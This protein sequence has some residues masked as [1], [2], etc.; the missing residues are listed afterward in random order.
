MISKFLS[1]IV[2]L[3]LLIGAILSIPITV[4][5]Q[6]I[7]FAELKG[8]LNNNTWQLIFTAPG[9]WNYQASLDSK[10][11]NL[12]I[13]FQPG[14]Q[15]SSLVNGFLFATSPIN[16][17]YPQQISPDELRVVFR[18]R[19]SVNMSTQAI[20]GNPNELIITLSP[21]HAG[22]TTATQPMVPQITANVLTAHELET[23]MVE[24]NEKGKQQISKPITTY[25]TLTSIT[26]TSP[27][28]SSITPPH[29]NINVNASKETASHD[30]RL[31]HK[32]NASATM[33]NNDPI[34]TSERVAPKSIRRIVI[35]IDPG[36]GG[37]DPGATGT[38]GVHEKNVV[39]SI[40]QKL[41]ALINKQPGFYAVLTRQGDYFI[42]LRQRMMIAR[43]DNADM[44]I[45]IHADA[46]LN[47]VAHGASVYA[48]SSR[49]ATSEA[50]RWL[51]QRENQSE[52]MGGVDLADKEDVLRSVLINLSQTATIHASLLIGQNL[53]SDLNR[54]TTLH[55][56]RV[57][58]AAFVVLKS[59]DIPSLLVE[60]GFLSNSTEERN[61][62][63]PG[64]QQKIAEALMLGIT[65]YFTENPPP[66][67]WL[68]EKQ[69]ASTSG[70]VLTGETYR[71][72]MGDNLSLIAKRYG[73][74]AQRIAEENH[75]RNNVLHVGQT[76]K[77][78]TSD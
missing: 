46:Y 25:S 40:S 28:K 32:V 56:S 50:A 37:K 35:V 30:E 36:H 29:A 72:K 47:H 34:L 10:S 12:M 41:Q 33:L 16:S 44:F 69:N 45:A 67:T 55:Y 66:N 77:I 78:D 2:R 43:Q 49:G 31:G 7:T 22:M 58:Q 54:F 6:T 13:N 27:S 15:F 8:P 64:Y 57:E 48:L 11:E 68:A 75:L 9:A 14:T 20:N 39:L 63:D 53:L 21:T 70:T 17:M 76:L 5:A 23:P 62:Q 61:L 26:S 73:L 38:H 42:P 51:A 19:K 18:L 3:L 71:V 52:L 65:R 74:S 60:T 1:A 24:E 4:F 59:P